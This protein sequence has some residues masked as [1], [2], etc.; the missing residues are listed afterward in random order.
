MGASLSWGGGETDFMVSIYIATIS[1]SSRLNETDWYTPP[2]KIVDN[3]GPPNTISSGYA[4]WLVLIP[5]VGCV[6]QLPGSVFLHK[7]SNFY[8]FAP[9]IGIADAL[10]SVVLAGKAVVRGRRWKE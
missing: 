4:L 8:R 1:Y 5:A 10:A 9:E 2:T 7:R 3:C 6:V